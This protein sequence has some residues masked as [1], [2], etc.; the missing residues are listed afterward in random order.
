M[1]FGEN[2]TIDPK[3]NQPVHTAQSVED[4]HYAQLRAMTQEQHRACRRERQAH[5]NSHFEGYRP[6][7]R[8]QQI[9]ER[10]AEQRSATLRA[11]EPRVTADDISAEHHRARASVSPAQNAALGREAMARRMRPTT[12]RHEKEN[13]QQLF[14]MEADKRNLAL[15]EAGVPTTIISDRDVP[16]REVAGASR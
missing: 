1:A 6:H 12:G 4:E 15:D 11:D 10:E 5:Q 9:F 8:L 3:H 7:E 2:E 16:L 14:T 13:L